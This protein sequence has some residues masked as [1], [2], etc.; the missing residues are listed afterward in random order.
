MALIPMGMGSRIENATLQA[1]S[2][3]LQVPRGAQRTA[4][5]MVVLPGEGGCGVHCIGFD[6]CRG[7]GTVPEAR[8]R[9]FPP[10]VDGV[11]RTRATPSPRFD[12]S[13]GPLMP[14]AEATVTKQCIVCLVPPPG[15]QETLMRAVCVIAHQLPCGGILLLS[16]SPTGLSTRQP[17]IY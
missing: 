10:E 17:A 12:C 7:C 3:P 6:V 8:P 9:K 11:T 2:G 14:F 1:Q 4:M 13:G 5:V 15:C 16:A